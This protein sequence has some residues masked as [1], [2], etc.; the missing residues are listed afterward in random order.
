MTTIYGIKNCDTMKK[1]FKWLDEYGIEYEFHDF[2]KAGLEEKTLKGWIKQVGW[3]TLVNTRGTTWRKLPEAD[4]S[5][6]N[7]ARAI[8]LMLANPSLV[9][10]PVLKKGRKLH[11]GFNADEYA[12]LFGA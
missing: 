4:R 8:K 5:N 1:A 11:V 6:I 12:R 3:E 9:K 2:K 7:E 10:R